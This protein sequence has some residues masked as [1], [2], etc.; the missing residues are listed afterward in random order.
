MFVRMNDLLVQD[1]ALA[2]LA[3]WSTASGHGS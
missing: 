1:V 3:F 2:H